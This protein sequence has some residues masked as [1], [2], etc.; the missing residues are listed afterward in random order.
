MQDWSVH[1]RG[2]KITVMGLG[3]LGRGVGDAE[4]LAEMGAELTI[5]DLKGEVELA[6]SLARL[7]KFPTIT[8]RLGEHVLDD[9]RN[10]DY[11]VKAA[12]VPLDSPYIAE[13]RNNGIPIKMSASWFAELAG[14]PVVGVT[15]TR[16]KTTTTMLLYEILR[17]AGKHVLLGGNIR[18]VSTLALLRDVTLDSLALFELDSWQCQGWGEARMS[19]QVSVFTTFMRDHMNYYR[20][21]MARYLEDKAQIFLHQKPGDTFVLGTQ[22]KEWVLTTHQPPVEPSIAEANS[23]DGWD[24]A[25]PGDHNRDNAV[26]AVVAARA[27]GVQDAISKEVLARFRGAP[28]R[29]ELV[30]EVNGVA[31]YNDT[32]ATTPEATVAAL[33]ALDPE[34]KKNIVLIVGGADKGLPLDALV[35]HLPAH[36]KKV[37]FLAGGGTERLAPLCEP[38]ATLNTTLGDAVTEALAHAR[39][40]DTI[41]FSPAF[42]SF[43]MFANE[44]DRG[45]QFNALVESIPDLS[46]LKPKVRALAR[47]LQ[48]ACKR[49]GFLITISY[50]FRS[51]EE[52]EALYAKGRTEPGSIVT[53]ARGGES[54]HNY[55]VA[56]DI[57]PVASS[58]EERERLRLKAGPLGEALGLTWGGRWE[59][60]KDIPHFEYTLDYSLDDFK[61]GLVDETRFL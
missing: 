9:F 44:Y 17:A 38:S 37:V 6:P 12:G 20:D 36:A 47:A 21:D 3:L 10:R 2:K 19:P 11:I 28:G 33:R 32:T 53:N 14:I 46:C 39:E 58:P 13:A 15:G 18:G 48:E 52:Q 23:I 54:F 51:C 25:M 31:L 27:L 61:K 16:G 40:G 57:R 55:G 22:A 1:F 7:K 34:S 41:L 29:L 60:F 24:V 59:T 49:E 5:T 4:F 50:G 30:R 8:Y 42:A 35:S 56:F 43:G 45:D 26:C